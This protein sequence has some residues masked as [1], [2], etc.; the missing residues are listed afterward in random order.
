MA[1]TLNSNTPPSP[2]QQ[3]PRGLDRLMQ[4][5][6]RD[7]IRA[8]FGDTPPPPRQPAP[9]PEGEVSFQSI[10]RYV[11]RHGNTLTKY[12][13]DRHGMGFNGHPNEAMAFRFVKAN[14]TIPVPEVIS[15][16]WDR[17][18][19]QYVEGQTLKHAWSSLTTD[20]RS[21][22]TNELRGYI[23]QLQALASRSDV[24]LGRLDGQGAVLPTNFPRSG[25]PFSSL[26]DLQHWLVHP[27]RRS[28]KQSMYWHQITTQLVADYPI[29]FT[30]GDIAARNIMVRD[31][32][33]VAILDW[34]YA[35]CYPAY[36][37]YTLALRGLDNVGWET[38]GSHLP[39]RFPK[40]YDL[41]YILMTFVLML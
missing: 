2:G 23:A 19:M 36:W 40:R 9:Y 6:E 7:R 41:E 25:G 34:E 1:N 31:G 3:Q 26:A 29:I 33:V 17:I 28:E 30:Y 11:V 4:M 21:N 15:S 13:T 16:D 8:M 22:V 20:Q 5:R 38:L 10:N 35:G 14:T 37:D 27:P 32:H 39:S 12:T 24:L 18:T